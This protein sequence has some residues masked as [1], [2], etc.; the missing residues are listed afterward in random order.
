VALRYGLILL[1]AMTLPASAQ[2]LPPL[3]GKPCLRTGNIADYRPLPGY[4]GLIVV[5]RSRR[6]YRLSF[7]A[8]C[9][10]LQIH[11]DLGFKTL[12]PSQYACLSTGDSVYSSRDVESNRLC[13]IQAIEY[14]NDEPLPSGPPPPEVPGRRLRG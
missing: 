4:R 3:S 7:T 1:S 8:I 11:P 2:N 14:F 6:Q 12:N 10:S 9:T 5:D 13:R